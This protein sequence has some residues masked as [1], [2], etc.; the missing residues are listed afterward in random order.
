MHLRPRGRPGALK[1]DWRTRMN[2][3]GFPLLSALLWTPAVGAL[4]LLVLPAA[5]PALHRWVALAFTGAALIL[6]LTTTAAF[7]AG[8]GGAAADP[9]LQLVERLAW[10]PSWGSSYIVGVDGLNLWLVL[11]TAFLAPFAVAATWSRFATGTRPLLALLLL[12][13]TAFLGVF[14]VQDLLLFY[15][16]YEM[17]L[18]P[19]VFLVGMWGGA[20]RGAAALKLFLYT[21]ASSVLMLVGII[22]LYVLH[23]SAMGAANPGFTGTFDL[24]Q[25]TADLRSGA[26]TLSPVTERLLFGAFFAAFAVK[27]SLWPLHTWVPDAYGAAPT[28]AA[29]MLAGVMAKFGTYGLIRFNLGL[30]PQAAD[31]AAPAVAVLAVIGILYAATVA[32]AQS[33][34]QRLVAYSSVSHMNFIVLGIFALNPIGI[35]GAI[36]QMVAHGLTIAFLFLMVAVLYERREV[37]ELS[38]FSGIW[39]QMPAY[40]GL[41]LFGLLAAAGLPGLMSFIGEFTIMQ[42]VL[43]SPA[44]GWP[45]AAGAAVGVILA[46]TYTLRWFRIAFMGEA[47]AALAP[48]LPDLNGRERLLLGALTAA[49][50]AFGLFPNLLLASIGGSVDTLVAA[51]APLIAPAGL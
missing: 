19:M 10:L 39:K 45:F 7:I 20:G 11:L 34:M 22:A 2:P 50:V 43:I 5:R 38:A 15:A 26:F 23:R 13:E 3:L 24:A 28:S 37:R 32:F 35:N 4:L 1:E 49:L 41:A 44:L 14:L 51:L 8:P 18:L 42:G 47:D 25:I 21:F 6:A 46:A 9:S 17:S 48:A 29:I 33:D 16:F 36:F 40:G 27:L 31:W 12:A 30:F